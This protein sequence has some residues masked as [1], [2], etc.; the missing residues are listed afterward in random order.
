MN[1]QHRFDA[2]QPLPAPHRSDA[3]DPGD[4]QR[5]LDAL[6]RRDV[7]F[8]KVAQEICQSSELTS[9]VIRLAHAVVHGLPRRPMTVEHAVGVLGLERLG[10]AMRRHA[11][12][13]EVL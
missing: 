6:Q 4:A 7:S 13:P 8:R 11:R 3:I 5:V 10:A 2:Q 9:V 12:R 1:K